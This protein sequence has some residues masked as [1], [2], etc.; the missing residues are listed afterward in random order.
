MTR[1]L[2]FPD[3]QPMTLEN[4]LKNLGEKNVHFL[5]N[6]G[7]A[8]DGLIHAGL[9]QMAKR[10]GIQLETFHYPEDRR[11]KTLLI[12]GAGAFCRV[13]WHKVDAVNFYS[14]RFDKVCVLPATFETNFGPV[15]EMLRKLP[16][17]VILFCR[18]RISYEAALELAPLRENILLD[19]DL[20]FVIDA[21]PWKKAGRGELMAFRT[22][23][24][25]RYG[26]VPMPN[27]DISNMGREYHYRLI[28]DIVSNYESVCTDRL[29]VS[30]AGALLGRKVKLF[31]GSYHK[32]KGIYEYSLRD[33]FP[34]V[35]LCGT[36]ELKVLLK[37]S[38]R[39]RMRSAVYKLVRM[40]PGTQPLLRSLKARRQA[41]AGAQGNRS[42]NSVN[43][44]SASH[45][46]RTSP[47]G[48]D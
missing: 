3:D 6:Q 33:R 1:A 9:Y 7:N 32:I 2:G 14:S 39:V 16:A 24:E 44:P 5:D 11:G 26:R 25:S 47:D 35:M 10:L 19:H 36:D 17:N 38:D 40:I 41:E 31:E 43:A 18:E 4:F 21:T 29:H 45:P 37:A 8:G 23:A 30:I 46:I 20:A 15:K 12:M 48:S 42:E 34:N 22:D 28:L 27:F 13:S